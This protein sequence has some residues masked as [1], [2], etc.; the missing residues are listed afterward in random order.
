MMKLC[1][2]NCSDPVF[3]RHGVEEK[4]QQFLPVM[5]RSC[6]SVPSCLYSIVTGTTTLHV[7]QP[8]NYVDATCIPWWYL[9]TCIENRVKIASCSAA[10]RPTIFVFSGKRRHRRHRN[11][12]TLKGPCTNVK[13]VVH[14]F[15]PLVLQPRY[16]YSRFGG[17]CAYFRHKAM[18]D[19][20]NKDL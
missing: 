17:R 3:L 8:E 15:Q 6:C 5:R 10:T 12:T 16:D 18:L 11:L 9:S 1:H 13:R 19:V 14:T 20:N 4:C 7:L 2:I